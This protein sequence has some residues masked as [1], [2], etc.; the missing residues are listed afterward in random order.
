[1]AWQGERFAREKMLKQFSR[2]LAETKQ[3][4]AQTGPDVLAIFQ[5]FKK[6]GVAVNIKRVKRS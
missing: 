4:K 2:Y 5:N 3:K 6:A 1:M